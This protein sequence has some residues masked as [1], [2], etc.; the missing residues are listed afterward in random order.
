MLDTVV[1]AQLDRVEALFGSI[2][3]LK[4]NATANVMHSNTLTTVEQR[5]CNATSGVLTSANSLVDSVFPA[6]ETEVSSEET[7][8][9][10]DADD[11]GAETET[12][13]KLVHQPVLGHQALKLLKSARKFSTK[14]RWWRQQSQW[15]QNH[16]HSAPFPSPNPI[17]PAHLGA[18]ASL[19]ACSQAA[20]PSPS[21]L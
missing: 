4:S 6:G 11:S 20:Q 1:N 16:W 2:T 17:S 12:E 13:V 14:V 15:F 21:P 8:D 19:C 9:V 18:S 10:E 7:D 5:L 3:A